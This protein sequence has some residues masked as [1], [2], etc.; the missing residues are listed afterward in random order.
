MTLLTVVIPF[1]NEGSNVSKCLTQLEDLSKSRTNMFEKIK[2]I[3]VND[4]S[5]DNSFTLNSRQTEF[6]QQSNISL[7]NNKSNLGLKATELLMENCNTDYVLGIPGDL[8]YNFDVISIFFNNLK[9]HRNNYDIF[10]TADTSDRRGRLRYSASQ[11]VN[12]SIRY[13]YKNHHINFLE[14]NVGLICLRPKLLSFKPEELPNWGSMP[15]Y[16]FL[17]LHRALS[18]KYIRYDNVNEKRYRLIENILLLS[19]TC[20]VLK[21]FY[22]LKKNFL[23]VDSKIKLFA[24]NIGQSSNLK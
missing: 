20:D 12:L 1:Y 23:H 22:L 5:T 10:A 3:L 14:K 9:E 13:L 21:S 24:F 6:L 4:C 7:I 8:R 19:R 11:F 15:Y 16:K 2:F 18:V 17:L